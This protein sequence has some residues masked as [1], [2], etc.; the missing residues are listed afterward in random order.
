MG[1]MGQMGQVLLPPLQEDKSLNPESLNGAPRA[2]S[3]PLLDKDPPDPDS[4]GE[5][6]AQYALDYL[7]RM[8]DSLG[9][10]AFNQAMT[11]GGYHTSDV[12]AVLGM[13]PR[14][15]FGDG[16][17]SIRKVVNKSEDE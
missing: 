4:P 15:V 11:R 7:R 12:N 14:F 5:I 1:Q 3:A 10:T 17:V 8:G 9:E 16:V 2:P 13:D 6:M